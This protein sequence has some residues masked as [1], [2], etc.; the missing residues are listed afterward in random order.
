MQDVAEQQPNVTFASYSRDEIGRP[1]GNLNMVMQ[2]KKVTAMQ[3]FQLRV[4]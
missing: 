3:I 1:Q 4:R 2:D